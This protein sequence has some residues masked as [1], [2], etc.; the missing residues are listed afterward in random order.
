MTSTRR[1]A[2]FYAAG[3]P[4]L[5]WAGRAW[6]AKLRLPDRRGGERLAP[7]SAPMPNG[8]TMLVAGPTGGELDQWA[9]ALVP[10][11]ARALAPGAVVRATSSGGLDGV[12]GANQFEARVAPDGTTLLLAPGTAALT[13]LAGDPRAHFDVGR[14][15]AVMAGMTSGIVAGTTTLVPGTS[16]RVATAGPVGPDMTAL[17]ALEILGVEPVA[18][19]TPA[20]PEAIREAFARGSIDFAFLR[21]EQIAPALDGLA[22]LGARPLF[23]LGIPS[24]EGQLGRDPAFADLPHLTEIYLR[25]HRQPPTGH[26][27]RA[28]TA[29]SVAARLSFCLILPALTPAALIALWRQAGVQ[30]IRAPELQQT[31]SAS[32]VH[33][34]TGAE[35]AATAAA[36]A[37]DAPAQLEL[38]HWLATRLDWHPGP[39]PVGL[40]DP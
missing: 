3:L 37:P 20:E 2:F 4:A 38:R 7:E 12:T 40:S 34:L 29:T 19:L 36:L 13:W 11:L 25:L 18:V 22:R 16:A 30:A 14:W 27:F 28:F 9:R 5:C 21:G 1:R 26:L 6:S 32:L 8:A 24:A 33:P 31:A 35:A 39:E 15:V 10:P 17:L 23:S